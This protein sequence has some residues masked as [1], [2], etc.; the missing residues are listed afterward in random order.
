MADIDFSAILGRQVGTAPEPKPLPAGTYIGVI[1]GLP[2]A[3]AQN[4]KEGPKGILTVTFKLIEAMDNVDENE[5]AEAGGLRRQDGEAK[6]MKL[7]F[8]LED[9]S[10]FILDRFMASFGFNAE[11]G[12]T[13]VEAFEELP[14]KEV[15]LEI[16]RRSYTKDGETRTISDIKRAVAKD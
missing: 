13:F 5:L 7:D 4:T 2:K 16:E 6:T 10:L 3:R 12:K 14:G 11:S 9:N 1:D 15:V 8:W